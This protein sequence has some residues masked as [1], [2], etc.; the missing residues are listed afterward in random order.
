[1]IRSCAKCGSRNRVPPEHLADTGR[2]GSCHADLPP[3]S[4]P[5]EADPGLFEDVIPIEHITFFILRV[6]YSVIQALHGR[7]FKLL[8]QPFS[9][10]RAA[11]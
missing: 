10:K 1:M 3:V 6:P 5:I 4:E 11:R 2:C 9:M 7:Q 8:D